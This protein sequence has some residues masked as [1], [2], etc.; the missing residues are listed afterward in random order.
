MS[1]KDPIRPS[2]GRQY[3][4]QHQ[5]VRVRWAMELQGRVIHERNKLQAFQTVWLMT[6]GRGYIGYILGF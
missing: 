5:W 3:T 6:E 1:N 4:R 2:D